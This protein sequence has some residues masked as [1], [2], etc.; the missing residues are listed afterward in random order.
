MHGVWDVGKDRVKLCSGWGRGRNIIRCLW[1]EQYNDSMRDSVIA[2][3]Y[4]MSLGGVD[5]CGYSVGN[6]IR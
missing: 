1:V 6:T 2:P 4:S 3:L 5:G